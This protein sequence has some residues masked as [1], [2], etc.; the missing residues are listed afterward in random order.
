M[1]GQIASPV[2]SE[3]A[4]YIRGATF[5]QRVIINMSKISIPHC[6]RKFSMYRYRLGKNENRIFDPSSG[7]IGIRLNNAR[8]KFVRKIIEAMVRKETGTCDPANRISSP[9]MP[10]RKILARIPAM[11]T[12]NFPSRS[13]LKL[14][15]L[16]GT[17]SAQPITNPALVSIK[18][19]GKIT[20]PN[21]SRCLSGF[22]VSLS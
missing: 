4:M 7:G 16:Y 18:T 2:I 1:R 5:P 13:C 6:S 8:T 9:K 14:S 11:A 12:I 15:G 21:G 22:N 19:R 17:G 3:K 20:E 10:A